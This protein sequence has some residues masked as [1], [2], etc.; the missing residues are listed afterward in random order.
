VKF[1]S[2]TVARKYLTW[3]ISIAECYRSISLLALEFANDAA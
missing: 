3:C 1:S 2:L